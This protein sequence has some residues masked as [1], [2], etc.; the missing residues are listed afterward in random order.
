MDTH[1]QNDPNNPINHEP[2]TKCCEVCNIEESK[3]YFVEDSEICEDCFYSCCGDELNQDVRIC[4]TCK[5][6]N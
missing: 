2:Q 3:T 1:T 4:P 5:E 6:H